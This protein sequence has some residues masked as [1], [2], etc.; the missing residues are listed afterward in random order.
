M[1][2]ELENVIFLDRKTGKIYNLS[3]IMDSDTQSPETVNGMEKISLALTYAQDLLAAQHFH[4]SAAEAIYDIPGYD[5]GHRE[6]ANLIFI[7]N[8]SVIKYRK[9]KR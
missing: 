7:M 6:D 5:G 8:M 3:Q 9:Q 4:E 2:K 1:P